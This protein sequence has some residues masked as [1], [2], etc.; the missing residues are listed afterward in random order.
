MET[1]LNSKTTYTYTT[2]DPPGSVY[3]AGT[4][5][6]NI[7]DKGEVVGFYQDSSGQHGFLLDDHEV[8]TTIDPPGSI[9]TSARDINDKGQIAGVYFD[10]SSR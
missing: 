5:E 2:I 10:A 7:N 4:I 9:Q 3:T 1:S 6:G 8:Y